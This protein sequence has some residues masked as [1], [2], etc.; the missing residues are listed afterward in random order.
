MASQHRSCSFTAVHQIGVT[1]ARVPDVGRIPATALTQLARWV[2][3][4]S[5]HLHLAARPQDVQPGDVAEGVLM[6]GQL[7]NKTQ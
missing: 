5:A 1:N 6:L 3:H 4:H 7:E 2:V